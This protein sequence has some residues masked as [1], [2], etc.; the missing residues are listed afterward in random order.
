MPKFSFLASMGFKGTA[1]VISSGPSST[2]L[3]PSASKP[4]PNITSSTYSSSSSSPT[5][6]GGGGAEHELVTAAKEQTTEALEIAKDAEAMLPG[7]AS[8]MQ[9]QA[10]QAAISELRDWASKVIYYYYY[11]FS[12]I[13]F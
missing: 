8:S 12:L 2:S 6:S 10:A 9:K 4:K 7:L 5:F 11:Y 13:I 3:K 1:A